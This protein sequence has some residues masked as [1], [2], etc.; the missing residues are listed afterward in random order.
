MS[1]VL[2]VGEHSF[3]GRE[4]TEYTRVSYKNFHQVDLTQ[5]DVVLNCALH[6]QYK[7]S[8]YTDGID[9][10]FEVGRKACEYNCHF[11]MLS[12]SK[13]YPEYDD[14]T[15]YDE[16]SNPDPVSY[17]GE[18]KLKTELKFLA[19]FPDKVT[20]LRGS[21]IFG[22]EYGRNSF[23]GYCMSQ[24]VN[25]GRIQYTINLD[26]KR[27]FL[28]VSD[29]VTMIKGVAAQKPLGVYN[30]SSGHPTTAKFI[31]ENLIAGY[32][33]GGKLS[34]T[35]DKY[36]RQF[37]LDNTKLK[38]RLGIDIDISNYAET[39]KNLGKLLNNYNTTL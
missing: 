19:N 1:N 7:I 34:T 33:Y 36:E 39:M 24:L 18:N 23:M 26:T 22:F 6:P 32:A 37:V 35:S 14:L 15:V 9:V 11:I 25:E 31:A 3:I 21:N 17:Y 5:F 29:A 30:L 20:I 38:N 16:F 8:G 10:D 12:T 2:V 28:Y 4:L 27:D 13:V